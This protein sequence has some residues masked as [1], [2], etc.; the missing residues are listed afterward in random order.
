M[1]SSAEPIVTFAPAA[2][3][4]T[5]HAIE[6]RPEACALVAAGEAGPSA[7]GQRHPFRSN[8]EMRGIGTGT[9]RKHPG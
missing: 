9:R 7:R 3:L 4:S 8:S 6:L 2:M 1:L 5:A